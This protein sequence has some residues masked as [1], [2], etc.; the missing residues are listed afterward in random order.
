MSASPA[1]GD[2]RARR[3][4]RAGASWQKDPQG[5]RER[6]LAEAARLFARNGYAA[7]TTGQ[8][9]AAAG[10]AEGNVFHYFGSKQN[11]LCE[12]GARWGRDF[13]AAMFEG[14]EPAASRAIIDGMV[15]RAFA[16]VEASHGGFG[17]FLLS[18]HAA[19]GPAVHAANRRAVT[20]EVERVLEQ[21]SALGLVHVGDGR[22]VAELLFGLVEAA[23]RACF[24]DRIDGED[25]DGRSDAGTGRRAR[26]V[27]AYIAEV[28]TAMV[29]ILELPA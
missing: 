29:R 23:L 13:A 1:R 25:A 15:R 10:V 11:L 16:F 2:A 21:W 28:V 5:R 8:I 12:V 19:L 17:L 22:I 18:S 20:S 14:V 6:V 26:R 3:P 9:A 7:V 27:E 4:R 24:V